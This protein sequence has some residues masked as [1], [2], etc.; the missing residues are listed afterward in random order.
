MRSDVL[1]KSREY[2]KLYAKFIFIIINRYVEL[3]I[4]ILTTLGF[5]VKANFKYIKYS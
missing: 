5:F 3:Y 2:Y 4:I 1:T